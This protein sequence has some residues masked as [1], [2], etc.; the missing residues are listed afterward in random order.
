[1]SEIETHP[2][3]MPTLQRHRETSRVSSKV[4]LRAYEVY[5]KVYG[6]QEAIITDGCR[7]GFGVGELITLLYAFS[8]PEAEWEKRV[9]EAYEGMKLS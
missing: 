9:D 4:T 5:K 2:I 1:M 3:Q 6:P 7:G 8:F